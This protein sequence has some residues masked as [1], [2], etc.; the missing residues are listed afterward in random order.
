MGLHE[1][2]DKIYLKVSL[3]KIR[4]K[5]TEGTPKAKSRELEDKTTIWE[6][7]YNSIDGVLVGLSMHEHPEY[8]KSWTVE[9]DD[10]D[11]DGKPVHYAIQM[12]EN[13]RYGMDLLRKIPNL[14][15]GEV[16]SFIPYDFEPVAG[17]RKSGLSIKTASGEKIQ[18]FYQKFEGEGDHVTVTNINGYP[19]FTGDKKD[20]DDWKVYFTQVTKILRVKALKYISEDFAKGYNA[21]VAA[22]STESELEA[23]FKKNEPSDLPF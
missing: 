15:K 1:P 6:L 21:P 3:G 7:I 9:I 17:D 19:D 13:G 5:V 10:E 4:K 18:S 11:A 14:H 2:S 23:D 12:Q 22:A 8:G 16:Y 20:K